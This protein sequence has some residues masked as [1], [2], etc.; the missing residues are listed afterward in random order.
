MMSTV[1]ISC[2]KE[3]G[4]GDGL[5][6]VDENKLEE[7]K[8]FSALTSEE[9]KAK[10]EEEGVKMV[11][12]MS[13]LATSSSVAASVS[14]GYH[15]D[16][17]DP[18]SAEYK[19]TRDNVAFEVV[20]QLKAYGE[21]NRSLAKTVNNINNLMSSTEDDISDIWNDIKGSYTWNASTE[22]WDYTSGGE[23]A[24]FEFPSEME[25]SSNNATFTISKVEVANVDIPEEGPT[26]IPTAIEA[27]MTIDGSEVMSFT[28]SAS[29]TSDGLPQ[30]S[31]SELTLNDYSLAYSF[32]NKENKDVS[33]SMSF[34]KGDKTM[35]ASGAEVVGD[36]NE[37]NIEDQITSVE[38]C[39]CWEYY[40]DESTSSYDYDSCVH[41]ECWEY[42]EV[43]VGEILKSSNAYFQVGNIVIGGS[44]DMKGLW[45]KEESVYADEDNEDFDWEAANKKMIESLGDYVELY[46]YYADSEQKIADAEF[47]AESDTDTWEDCY[48]DDNDEYVCQDV[49]ETYYYPGVRMVFGDDSPV[50]METYFDT[51]FD[52]VISAMNE[53]IRD[54]NSKYDAGLET[55]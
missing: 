28:A 53:M 9:H 45:D 26:E 47:Y 7:P 2:D 41:E 8:D 24:I 27:N 15:L 31:S 29:Y 6:S 30:K 12:D 20:Y 51:G 48:Y 42:E 34:K 17:D 49:T 55:L 37:S 22:S 44:L 52:D 50:D 16:M 32:E 40:W 33:A 18:T 23:T 10:L 11:N 21:G 54:I 38:E 46:V 25:G 3:D 35:M 36:F 39:D 13:G 1:F 5:P 43:N 14:L 4:D 19:S